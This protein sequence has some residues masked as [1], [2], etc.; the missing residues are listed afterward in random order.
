[1]LANYGYSDGSGDY[2]IAID[3]D[4]CDGCGDCV[5]ACPA[6][7]FAVLSEDPNDPLRDEPVAVVV[8]EKKKKVAYEC[9]PCKPPRDRPPLPC[10][11][12]CKA[13]AIFHSW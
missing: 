4:K 2:F 7:L 10:V 11:E 3:S 6:Q 1:M 9:N 13:G 12:A 8:A 5:T